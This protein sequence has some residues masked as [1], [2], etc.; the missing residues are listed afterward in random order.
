MKNI[1]TSKPQAAMN[2]QKILQYFTESQDIAIENYIFKRV[3]ILFT[4][5]ILALLFLFITIEQEK[6]ASQKFSF[7]SFFQT[8]P[9]EQNI[10]LQA[11]LE[12]PTIEKAP[13]IVVIEEKP[14]LPKGN[15]A[16]NGKILQ[17]SLSYVD[18][19]VILTI[20]YEGIISDYQVT[21]FD[22]D[23]L[24]SRIISLPGTWE[25]NAYTLRDSK[26]P[27]VR[28]VQTAN[29]KNEYRISISAVKGIRRLKEE[30][31]YTDKELKIEIREDNG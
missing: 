5:F 30:I 12:A 26:N 29:H 7:T 31:H 25:K 9:K 14:L 8:S 23:S 27:L 21:N 16:G 17:P 6:P 15:D 13:E 2:V 11:D 28:L 22:K 20:P 10:P 19:T 4:L 1:D 24:H 18:D 3:A